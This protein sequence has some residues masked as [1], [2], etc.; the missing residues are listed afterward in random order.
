[1]SYRRV[2]RSQK[3]AT[4]ENKVVK[5]AKAIGVLSIKMKLSLDA[6]WPDR[7]FLTPLR[8]FWIEFKLPGEPPRPLQDYKIGILRGLGYDV[9]VHDDYDEAMNAIRRRLK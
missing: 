3:E 2:L 8:P 4:V 5:D 9:E 7:L 6:G 1:M